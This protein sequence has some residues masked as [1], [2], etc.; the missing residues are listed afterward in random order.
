MYSAE[1]VLA[2]ATPATDDADYAALRHAVDA[3]TFA[4]ETGLYVIRP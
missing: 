2:V 4:V 1:P 3:G